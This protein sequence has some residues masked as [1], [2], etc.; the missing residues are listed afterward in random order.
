MYLSVSTVKIYNYINRAS[1]RNCNH[2]S[3]LEDHSDLKI[4]NN[5]LFKKITHGT[6]KCLTLREEPFRSDRAGQVFLKIRSSNMKYSQ[7]R[8][9]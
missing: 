3:Y 8:H 4:Y 9:V 5:N 7:M 1:L 6:Q 2:M